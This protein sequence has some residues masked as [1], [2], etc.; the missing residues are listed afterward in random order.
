[1]S[2]VRY[3][4]RYVVPAALLMLVVFWHLW[5]V[6]LLSSSVAPTL[7]L[8]RYGRTR[9]NTSGARTCR[10][11]S[12][13]AINRCAY[14]EQDRIGVYLSPRYSFLDEVTHAVL[15][16]EISWE[17]AE[18]LDTIKASP[19]YEPDQ[20]KACVTVPHIDTLNLNTLGA[21]TVFDMLN[22]LPG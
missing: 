10:A 2:I 3:R 15:T 13:F 4:W 14:R 9:D 19:F 16:P 21:N 6:H 1:M 22:S 11:N 18:L 8:Q 17:Y 20:R 12:C 5:R 7:A